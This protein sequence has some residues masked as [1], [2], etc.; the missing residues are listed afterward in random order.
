[1]ET[2]KIGVIGIGNMGTA[3]IAGMLK[4]GVV[5]KDDLCASDIS[6]QRCYYVS[7]TYGVKCFSD[8]KTLVLNSDIII[9]AVE[10]KNVTVILES[11]GDEL[12]HQLLI[13]IVAGISINFL[14]KNL[15]KVIPIIRCMPNNPCMVGE[16]MTVLAPSPEVSQE[17][18]N[19]AEEIFSSVGRVLILSEHLLDAVTGLSGSGPAY[20]YLVIEGLIDGGL[21]VGL[22]EDVA[23]IL[24]AQ[25]VLGAGKM[26][27]ETKIPPVRLR[28]M[29]TSPEGTTIEGLKELEKDN[30]KAS[31]SRAVE[32]A[33]QRSR[34]LS[35]IK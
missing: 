12:T 6:A 17:N 14:K 35:K 28:E 3:L 11:I 33:T 19:A 1:L 4:A 34:E 29:V 16:S 21:K 15:Q 31:F 8:S 23:L 25:T 9:V 18:L 20:I 27:L 5:R 32:R 30:I 10:P 13:S 7:K 2:K 24:A 26:I 22:P